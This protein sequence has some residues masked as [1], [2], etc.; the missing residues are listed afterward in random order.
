[1]CVFFRISRRRKNLSKYFSLNVRII[2]LI[3]DP[4]ATM[5]SRNTRPWCFSYDDCDDPTVLCN[6]LE[7][8]YYAAQRLLSSYPDRFK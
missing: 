2:Y 3:R 6:D 1:M 8:D 7:M 4:R 5:A